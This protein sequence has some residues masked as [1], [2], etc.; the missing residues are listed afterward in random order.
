MQ[1]L[2]ILHGDAKYLIA[3]SVRVGRGASDAAAV[4]RHAPEDRG[5]TVAGGTGGMQRAANF[6]DE[7]GG[8]GI[9]V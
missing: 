1:I 4:C 5:A 6:G 7:I 8:K 2:K 3:H 9:S